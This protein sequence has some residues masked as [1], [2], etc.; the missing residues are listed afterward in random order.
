MKPSLAILILA[1]AGLFSCVED[2]FL[3]L[4]PDLIVE[5]ITYDLGNGGNAGDIRIDFEVTDN[6]NVE[7]YRIMII[8]EA[9]SSTFNEESAETTPRTNYATIFPEAFKIEYSLDRL[10]STL[11]DVNGSPVGNDFNYVVAIYVVG[12]SERQLSQFTEPFFI[13]DR[14]IYEGTYEIFWHDKIQTDQGCQREF[15]WNLGIQINFLDGIY[16]GGIGCFDPQ[17]EHPDAHASLWLEITGQSITSVVDYFFL[18]CYYPEQSGDPCYSCELDKL[19]D[20]V[21]IPGTGIVEEDIE[22]IIDYTGEDCGGSHELSFI[23]KRIP[24]KSPEIFQ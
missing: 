4:N 24:G 17:C 3:P 14:P 6:L 15:N 23:M 7:E 21:I 13:R 20:S 12:K 8:L 16:S 18:Y 9:S 10:P 1:V 5:I 19:C 2:E 22:F 11:L